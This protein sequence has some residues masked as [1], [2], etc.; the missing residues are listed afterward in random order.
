MRKDQLPLSLSRLAIGFVGLTTTFAAYQ[1][2]KISEVMIIVS[3]NPLIACLIAH[4]FLKEQIK[5]LD[6]ALLV[7]SF[8]GVILVCSAKGER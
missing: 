7:I 1:Y 6:I 8:S 3:T 5:R 2:A 4:I